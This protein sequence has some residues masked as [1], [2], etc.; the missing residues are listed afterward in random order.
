MDLVDSTILLL[1]VFLM[2]IVNLDIPR[3][4]VQQQ[5]YQ[6]MAILKHE[7]PDKVYKVF[8]HGKL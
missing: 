4:T 7:D 3:T 6:K 2:G 5:K 8:S 1:A